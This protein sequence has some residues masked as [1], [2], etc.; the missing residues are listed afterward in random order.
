MTIKTGTADTRTEHSVAMASLGTLLSVGIPAA[1][2]IVGIARL[3]WGAIHW[4]GAIVWGVVA[5]VAFTAVLMAA[6]AM[7]TTRLD[8]FD[9]LGSLPA[10]RAGLV[11][12]HVNGALLA[13]AWAYGVALL[14]LPANWA[15]GLIWGAVIAVLALVL[16]SSIGAV[17]PAIRRGE[18]PDPGTAA[19]N[20]GWMTPFE[21]LLGHLV[22]GVVLGFLY[23]VWPL[24]W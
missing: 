23:S 24:A 19:V 10:R 5:A 9:L 7:G 4:G 20:F 22:Y 13:I 21:A 11:L 8:L 14:A 12:H 3:G 6:K 18:E 17:H 1:I 2:A 16:M 15:T